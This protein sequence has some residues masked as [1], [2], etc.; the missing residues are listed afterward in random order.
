M[1]KTPAIEVLDLS[2][3]PGNAMD[4]MIEALDKLLVNQRKLSIQMVKEG[5]MLTFIFFNS[6]HKISKD[7]QTTKKDRKTH[8]FGLSSIR[9]IVEAYGG[10]VKTTFN[11]HFINV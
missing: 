5:A 6:F 4:N 1:P 9:R 8:G 11:D 10:V 3:L 7:L 2:V